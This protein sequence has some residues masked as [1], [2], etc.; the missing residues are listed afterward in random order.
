MITIKILNIHWYTISQ[1]VGTFSVLPG[2]FLGFF[3][4]VCFVFYWNIVDLRY[5]DYLE[6]LSHIYFP[7]FQHSR[8]YHFKKFL[9]IHINF[10]YG[11]WVYS[12]GK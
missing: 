12:M 1:E 10:P 8:Y 11:N 7:S 4:P 2:M 6:Y 9:K 3:F 5:C